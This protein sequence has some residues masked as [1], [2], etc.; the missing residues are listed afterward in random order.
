MAAEETNMRE[1]YAWET[2]SRDGLGRTRG[3]L[4]EERRT[5]KEDK[6]SVKDVGR[7]HRR[8]ENR[9]EWREEKGP[10][11]CLQPSARTEEELGSLAI[12]DL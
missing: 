2:V 10:N 1:G 9:G 8:E 12:T 4:S 6:T 5:D 11:Y 3:W 7:R